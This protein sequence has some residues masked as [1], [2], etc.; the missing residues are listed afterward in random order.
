MF[1]NYSILKK[2]IK[3]AYEGNGLTVACTQDL[4]MI[5][6][7][8]WGISVMRRFLHN[9]VKAALTEYIGDLPKDGEAWTYIK[10]GKN[11]ESQQEMLDTVEDYFALKPGNVY[12][13]TDVHVTTFN[14]DY[15]VYEG[16]DM[17]KVYVN[18]V[19]NAL[20]SATNVEGARGEIQP[21]PWRSGGSGYMFRA[22]NVMTIYCHCYS[23]QTQLE[24]ELLKFTKDTSF[25][26]KDAF[27]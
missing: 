10:D 15:Q 27:I 26:E 1:V 13:P 12:M 21:E 11:T 14:G 25:L 6:S 8:R 17:H 24:V 22:N 5:Q 18:S 2:M 16:T 19:F 9:K 4:V 20:I 3:G 7:S 23:G